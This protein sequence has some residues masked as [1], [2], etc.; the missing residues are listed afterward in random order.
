MPPAI[1]TI[2]LKLLEC[3]KAST[4]LLVMLLVLVTW[5][6]STLWAKLSVQP[7]V[8]AQHESRIVTLELDRA[9]QTEQ[10]QAINRSLARIEA[11]VN[12]TKK[13]VSDLKN[14]LISQ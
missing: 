5:G 8:V 3:K 9:T 4:S 14:V 2:L 10:L 6:A 7:A 11:S 12:D 1:L 13:D